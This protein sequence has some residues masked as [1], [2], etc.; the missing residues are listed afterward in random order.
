M[1][2]KK[3]AV[4]ILIRIVMCCGVMAMVDGVIKP[5]YAKK[6]LVK[7]IL[8][9]AVP[10]VY[11]WRHKDLSLKEIFLWKKGSGK[12]VFGLAAGLYLGILGTYLVTRN[13]LDYSGITG[14]LSSNAGVTGKRFIWV[15]LYIS[16]ANSFLEEFFFRGFAFLTMKKYITRKAAYILSSAMFSLYHTAM[17]TGW[18]S[19][20]VY[21]MVLL[22]LYIGAM[23]F[24]YLNEKD[25]TI[26]GS[27][28]VHMSADFSISTIGLILFGIL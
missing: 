9:L 25:G 5:G 19:A 7:C 13:I 12:L 4:F 26:Y 22:G 3:E 23:I 11:F 20:G 8:F 27:W 6:S 14:A 2:K 16:F 10:L 21:V 17:M 28:F 1:K 15:A 24:N 18:F